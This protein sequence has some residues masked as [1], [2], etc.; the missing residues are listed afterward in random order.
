MEVINRLNRITSHRTINDVIQYLKDKVFPAKLS[1]ARRSKFVKDLEGLKLGR[2]DQ[3]IYEDEDRKLEFVPEDQWN[4]ILEEIYHDPKLVNV[5]VGQQTFYQV[6]CSKYFGI[7]RQECFAFLKKQATYQLTR[8]YRKSVY[9]NST[10]KFFAPLNG[11]ALDTVDVARYSRIRANKGNKYIMTCLDLF[12]RRVWF[13]PLKNKTP[14]ALVAGWKKA[15]IPFPKLTISD[16]GTEMAGSFQEFMNEHNVKMIHASSHTP[17]SRVE[18]ANLELRHALNNTFAKNHDFNWLDH[19][20]QIQDAM[21]LQHR[22]VFER[23][24]GKEKE[25]NQNHERIKFEIGDWVRIRQGA[26]PD[27]YKVRQIIKSK[28]TKY[29]PIKYSVEIYHIIRVYRPTSYNGLPMYAVAD[30]ENDS[31]YQNSNKKALLQF[32]QEDLMLIPHDTVGN[33]KLTQEV[34]NKLNM[35]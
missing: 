19:L 35:I 25:D 21:N 20:H 23:S 10:R 31:L 27:M 32:R 33:G 4:E 17:V 16:N 26:F 13:V 8:N 22:L 9:N 6:V 18:R 3:L 7:P 11:F 28:E 12:D 29:L 5:G 1:Y 34:S 15:N 30:D 24:E 14:D 2:N